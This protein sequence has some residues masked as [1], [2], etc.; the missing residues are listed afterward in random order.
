VVKLPGEKFQ[1]MFSHFYK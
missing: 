1:D